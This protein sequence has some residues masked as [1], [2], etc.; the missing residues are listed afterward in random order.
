MYQLPLYAGI[1]DFMATFAE[2]ALFL[3]KNIRMNIAIKYGIFKF[4]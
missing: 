3:A 1:L 4:F 2:K